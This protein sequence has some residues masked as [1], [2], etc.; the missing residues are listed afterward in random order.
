M[1]K[2]NKVAASKDSNKDSSWSNLVDPRNPENNAKDNKE[3][4]ENAPP[5]E[6]ENFS[7]HFYIRSD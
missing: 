6:E 7:E 2:K 1:I 5:S 4:N 3:N